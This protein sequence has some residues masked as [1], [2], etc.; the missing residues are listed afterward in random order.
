MR[1]DGIPAHGVDST[2]TASQ[3]SRHHPT[4]QPRPTNMLSWHWLGPM[5]RRSWRNGVARSLFPSPAIQRD[6]I[7]LCNP[8][9]AHRAFVVPRFKPLPPPPPR[10]NHIQNDR[11]NNARLATH[12]CPQTEWTYPIQAS[13][14][15]A[16]RERKTPT[17]NTNTQHEHG[18][19]A[20]PSACV[21]A[22]STTH[23]NKCPHC[24]MVGSAHSTAPRVQHKRC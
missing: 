13:P 14:A 11:E 19:S 17:S 10:S 6:D 3:T 12:A 16:K 21:R 23:Q 24:V 20:V 18:V 22:V 2:A 7:V 9:F 1:R 15:E 8:S 5:A 4:P